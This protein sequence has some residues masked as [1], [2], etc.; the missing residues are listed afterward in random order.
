MKNFIKNNNKET[1]EKLCKFMTESIN[2]ANINDVMEL[3]LNTAEELYDMHFDQEGLEF[4]PYFLSLNIDK[5]P[6]RYL[7]RIF[8]V[9]VLKYSSNEEYATIC[10]LAVEIG[11]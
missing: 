1:I 6:D 3:V 2:P 9:L 4:L 8:E 11:I 10:R 5:F 7:H